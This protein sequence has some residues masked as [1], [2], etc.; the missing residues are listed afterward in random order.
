MTEL[1]NHL[2]VLLR[3]RLLI[4]MLIDKSGKALI[5]SR[6]AHKEK[7]L[8]AKVTRASLA[9]RSNLYLLRRLD[10]EIRDTRVAIEV[11]TKGV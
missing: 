7:P 3:D 9:H 2:K 11:A 4:E 5:Q 8:D 6:V 10:E 1:E